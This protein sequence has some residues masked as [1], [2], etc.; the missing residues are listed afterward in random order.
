MSRMGL[1][2]DKPGPLLSPD[3]RRL[4]D[5]LS[6]QAALAIE[7]INLSQ[8]VESA[9]LTAETERLFA[10]GRIRVMAMSNTSGSLKAAFAVA[11]EVHD[12]AVSVIVSG[13]CDQ[14]CALVL[15][16]SPKRVAREDAYVWVSHQENAAMPTRVGRLAAEGFITHVLGADRRVVTAEIW[17]KDHVAECGG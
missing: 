13:W 12:R 10:S 16:A 3:Q 8:D 2:N 9:K 14:A 6:D 5:A 1:D 11:K 15:A 7:R 17:C 4:L